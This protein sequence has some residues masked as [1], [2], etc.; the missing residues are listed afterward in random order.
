M[1]VSQDRPPTP[2]RRDELAA[3]AELGAYLV[4]VLSRPAEGTQRV[5]AG[6]VFGALGRVASPVRRVHD[7]LAGASYAGVRAGARAVA[8]VV[9][10]GSSLL[11]PERTA[12]AVTS[13]AAGSVVVGAVNGLFGDHLFAEGNHLAV[14]LGP[15]HQRKVVG[16]ETALLALAHPDPARH[17]VVFVHGLGETE[18]AWWYHHDGRGSHGEHLATLEA[19]PVVLR[20]NTGR[21]VADN[22]AELARLMAELVRTWPVPVERI[23]LVGHSMGGLVLRDAC[24][25]TDAASWLPLVHT[26]AYLGT[27]HEGAPLA[28]GA[29]RLASL[30]RRRP[31]SRPWAELLELRSAGIL[32]LER[33]HR[34]PLATGV[35][36]VAVAAT[37]AADPSAWWAGAVGDGLVSV[38]S[39]KH[40]VP[41]TYVIP[42]TGHLALL[43]EPRVTAILTEL[44]TWERP[45][46]LAR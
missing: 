34:L 21:P 32:D 46:E 1:G 6:H 18:Q 13:T 24:S 22:G 29:A 9:G 5:I 8:R 7:A 37:L 3:A 25:R 45:P 35:R 2:R 27:P 17:V 38:A 16:A 15:H 23:D 14:H 33:A 20:Y 28:R 12:H 30:L 10:A 43:S 44:A 11:A 42:A 26:A 31:E 36:H 40:T 4:D 19:T 39:A 41:E